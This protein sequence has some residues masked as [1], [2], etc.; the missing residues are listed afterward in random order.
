MENIGFSSIYLQI[1]SERS[2]LKIELKL[3]H[4]DLDIYYL[5]LEN[6]YLFYLNN[7]QN[8]NDLKIS[9]STQLVLSRQ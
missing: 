7:N 1:N 2:K 4:T 6:G 8:K 3:I 9:G 5:I